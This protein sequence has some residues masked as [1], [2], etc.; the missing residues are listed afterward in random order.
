MSACLSQKCPLCTP[1]HTHTHPPTPSILNIELTLLLNGY[2]P[3][4]VSYHFKQFFKQNKTTSV[5]E[6][7]DKGVYQLLHQKLIA[8]LTRREQKQEAM[9]STSDASFAQQLQKQKHWDRTKI[10]VHF[11]FET[12][13]ML[14]F[15]EELRRLWKKHYIYKG[16]P[17]SNIRLTISSGTN[18][19]LHQLLVNKRP[20]RKMLTNSVS[21]IIEYQ[22]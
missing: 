7:L 1:T 3:K 16:S 9:A 5:F 18:K 12:G 11:T 17:M 14:E 8:Q 6:R 2:P 15:K 21:N 22:T 13:P 4:F 10:L 19:S 20:P